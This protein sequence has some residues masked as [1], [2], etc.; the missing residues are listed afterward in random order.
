MVASSLETASATETADPM[1]L[2]SIHAYARHRADQS[3]SG[4]SRTAVQKA[5]KTGRI[6]LT[7]DGK[8]DV[9]LADREWAGSTGQID[10]AQQKPPAPATTAPRRSPPAVDGDPDNELSSEGMSLAE[11]T[12]LEKMWKA[13]IAE[14][15]YRERRGELV[16][17]KAVADKLAGLF[18]LCRTKMLG[19]STRARQAMPEL[20]TKQIATYDKLIREALEQLS[21][22]GFGAPADDEEDA[23]A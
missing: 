15:D 6:H 10:R 22:T 20:T 8:V 16:S 18:T 9:E 12:R 14:L 7:P 11:A 21:D 4:R 13:S 17:A 5:I 2:V 3:L 1:P 19:V 23:V